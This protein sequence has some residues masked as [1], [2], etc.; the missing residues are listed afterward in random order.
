MYAFD[1][2]DRRTR[3]VSVRDAGAER[4]FYEAEFNGRL[5]NFE[6]AFQQIDDSAA[7][8]LGSLAAEPSPVAL[9]PDEMAELPSLAAMQ[10]LRTKLQRTT[11]AELMRQLE[12]EA[13]KFGLPVEASLTDADVR[14]V[15]IRR[16][17]DGEAVERSFREKDILLLEATGESRFWISD[18]PV[19][20]YNTLPYGRVG[21]SAPGIEIYLPISPRRALGFQCPSIA[22]HIAESLDPNHPRPRLDN[23]L[24]PAMLK[25]V[26]DHSVLAVNDNYVN[27]LNELQVRQSSRY[28]YSSRDDFRLA[29][30]VLD[31]HPQFASVQSLLAVGEMGAGLP[32]NP[33]MPP[34]EW[35]ILE[36]G[37]NHHAL[38]VTSVRGS[39]WIEFEPKD[40]TKLALAATDAPFNAA[41]LYDDGAATQMVRDVTFEVHERDGKRVVRMTH[42]DPVLNSLMEQ[43]A[44]DRR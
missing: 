26:G 7:R 37:T 21:L 24:Y 15:A 20:M 18:N 14:R 2:S 28:V 16:I 33:D 27:Y 36:S 31:R 6:P 39:A 9:S 35:L 29:E 42:V 12:R 5:I 4:D 43:I 40:E 34:G 8:I 17:L 38:P 32:P 23:P 30:S 22:K 19:A 11:P 3:V 44:Q 41:T 25:A 1:K 13:T 10:L